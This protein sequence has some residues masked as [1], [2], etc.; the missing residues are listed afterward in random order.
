[1]DGFKVSRIKDVTG[2]G[3]FFTTCTG[4]TSMYSGLIPYSSNNKNQY[5]I[6]KQN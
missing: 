4:Q 6:T 1:M 5:K 3:N 2:I